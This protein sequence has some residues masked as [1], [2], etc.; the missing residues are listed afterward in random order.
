MEFRQNVSHKIIPGLGMKQ[1]FFILILTILCS[2]TTENG[3]YEASSAIQLATPIV[4][5]D[6][7][8]FKNNAKLTLHFGLPK[9]EIRYTLDGKGVDHDSPLY[10]TPIA[11]KNSTTVT[12]KA[13][14]P[15]FK[16]SEEVSLQVEKITH[17]ISNATIEIQPLPHDN[18][19]GSGAQ[20]M[21]DMHKGG[22]QF[23]GGNKWMGF[24]A[25]PVTINMDLAKAMELSMVKVSC[26]Q[27]QSGWIFGPKKI[28][29][30]NG[31][32]EIG[33]ISIA[34]VSEKQDNRLKLISVP[35][36]KGKYAQLTVQIYPLDEIPQWHQGKGSAPW[37]FLDEILVE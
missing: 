5:V 35:L 19:K 1:I 14:H 13:F 16:E 25:N 7:L 26:L 8:F 15:D 32:Q 6:S 30:L 33:N 29:V 31:S 23:R 37:L 34:S 12:I 9:S 28:R 3:T 21:V 17:D 11:L 2:C 24:Q 4:E 27:N 20:G 18:Y 36:K 22:L 10:E